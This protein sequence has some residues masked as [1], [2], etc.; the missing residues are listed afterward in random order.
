[1]STET[2]AKLRSFAP[3]FADDIEFG[4]GRLNSQHIAD[5]ARLLP[6]AFLTVRTT[7]FTA[8]VRAAECRAF[9]NSIEKQQENAKSLVDIV[10][11]TY[12]HHR[13][14]QMHNPSVDRP[15]VD[16]IKSLML[17]AVPGFNSLVEVVL[18][19]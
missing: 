5:I 18:A 4:H 12:G 19:E 1:M 3:D 15:T 6:G 7:L 14:A 8:Q 11:R 16:E 17:K 10:Y 9:L 13:C 2:L